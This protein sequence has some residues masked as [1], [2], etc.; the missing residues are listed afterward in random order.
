MRSLIKSKFFWIVIAAIVGFGSGYFAKPTSVVTKIE[1]VEVIRYVENKKENKDIST[2]V[3]RITKKDGT[4]VETITTK[5]KTKSDSNTKLDS[6][7]KYSSETVVKNDIGLSVHL[8]ALTRFNDLTYREY[9]V[10]VKKRLFSNISVGAVVTDKK[11]IGLSVGLD[12]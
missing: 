9:G 11:T 1:E 5:D 10:Y 3:K 12:F 6:S 7:K 2:V 4:I 8:L